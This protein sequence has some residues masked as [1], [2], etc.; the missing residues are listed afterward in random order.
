MHEKV[1]YHVV[2]TN[3]RSAAFVDCEA[4]CAFV[5]DF[6]STALSGH[7]GFQSKGIRLRLTG[8]T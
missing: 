4:D 8:A 2:L 1:T 5:W 6:R 7:V 3:K